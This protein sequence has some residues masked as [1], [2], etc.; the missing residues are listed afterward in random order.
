ML[1]L[2]RQQLAEQQEERRRAQA[3]RVFVGA[4]QGLT[5]DIAMF[6]RNASEFPVYDAQIWYLQGG[7]LTAP[8]KLGII[9]PGAQKDVRKG[10]TARR[11]RDSRPGIPGR[12]RHPL[13]THVRRHG[14]RAVR[15]PRRSQHS[16]NISRQQR[17]G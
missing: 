7:G 13:D 12:G 9:M 3:L 17:P 1:E 14:Q 11:C 4:P 6:A 8:E 2:Q 10:G 15:R 5:N 16:R